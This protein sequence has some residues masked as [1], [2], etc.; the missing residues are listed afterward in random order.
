VQGTNNLLIKVFDESIKEEVFKAITRSDYELSATSEGSDIRVKLGTSRKEHITAGMAKV[1]E[2]NQTYKKDV[3]D[4]RHGIMEQL[5]KLKK[6][7]PEDDVKLLETEVN[8]MIKK[9]EDQA[10]KSCTA[11]EAD[12]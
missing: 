6:I 7:M 1:K 10:S 3:R 9:A 5:K 11:K 12:I 4:A 2:L 8:E